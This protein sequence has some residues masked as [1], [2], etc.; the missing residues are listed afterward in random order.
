MSRLTEKI[1]AAAAALKAILR[2]RQLILLVLGLVTGVIGAGA[3]VVFRDLIGL[4]QSLALGFSSERVAGLAAGQPWWRIMLAPALGGLV[5]GLFIHYVMPGRRPQGVPHVMEAVALRSGRMGLGAGIGAALASAAA[6]GTGASVGRE[7]P[8]VHLGASLSSWVAQRLHLS[9]ALTL[10][11]LGCGVAS[12]IA[13]SFNAPIAGAFFAL[14]VVVGHYALSSFAPIVIAS[15]TGTIITRIYYGNFPAFSIPPRTI[16]S[17][18]EFPAF[19][20]LGIICA[21]IAIAFIKGTGAVEDGMKRLPVPPWT[22]PGIAGLAVGIV[23]I[24]FPQVLGVGYE[25]NDA[26]I[27]EQYGL[28]LLLALLVLKLSL[29]ALCLGSGF[30][31]GVFSPSLVIGALG[32]AAFGAIAGGAFPHLFSGQG[33]YAIVG[34]GAVA[35]AVLGAPISTILIIFE[36]TGN[37]TLT[38]AVMIGVVIASVITRQVIGRSFFTEQLFRRGISLEGGRET[39]LLRSRRVA[40]IMRHDFEKIPAEARLPAVRARLQ[41]DPLGE[42]FVVEPD[43]GD[44][45]IGIITLADLGN[46]AFDTARDAELTARDV[47]RRNPPLLPASADL[48]E[49]RKAMEASAEHQLAVVADDDS[50]RLQGY[51]RERDVLAAYNAALMQARAEERGEA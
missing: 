12:A 51:V 4:I 19:A 11:L 9:R 50:R 37:F 38:I 23:A 48:E 1:S 28:G 14:E 35:G 32:G 45:F 34:M 26:A 20:L 47:M 10:T 36:L 15:V 6:I 16:A 17:F 22:K 21:L 39:G 2:H 30:A 8:V 5:V 31:G 43:G 46:A 7:G 42:L 13:A 3:A 41:A 40:E 33:A 27:A 29:S 18:L 49:A 44:R 25:T 24:W